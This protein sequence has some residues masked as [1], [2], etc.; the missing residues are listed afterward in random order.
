LN[1]FTFIVN[2]TSGKGRGERFLKE[3]HSELKNKRV[4]YEIVLTQGPGHA[5]ILARQANTDTVVAVGGDGTIQEVANGLVGS[6]KTLGII[7]AGSGNDFVKSIL[8]STRLG[9]AVNALLIGRTKWVDVGRVACSDNLSGASNSGNLEPRYFVNGV[10]I[11]FD[12]AV[13]DT[14]NRIAYL[15]GKAV[16]LLAV[17]KTLGKYRSPL[18]TTTIDSAPTKSKNL[19]IAIGNG[20]CAGGGFYLTPDAVVDDGLLDV[21]MINEISIPNILRIMPQIMKANHTKHKDVTLA[22]GKNILVS[23]SEPFF[24]HADG[25][26][27]GKNVTEVHVSIKERMLQVITG[28]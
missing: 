28:E 5:T 27:V 20:R 10:G 23:A 18:F 12:A 25:E 24:V 17:L 7:P 26:M 4:S 19:L 3:L 1:R 22:R 21:C 15:S 13:A 14:M 6:R 2:P 11:G 16:Y 9:A 8:I